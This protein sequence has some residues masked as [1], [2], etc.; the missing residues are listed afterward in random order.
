MCNHVEPHTVLEG[1]L[2]SKAAEYPLLFC[3]EFAALTCAHFTTQGPIPP[4]DIESFSQDAFR[5]Q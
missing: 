1:S 4:A 2:T 3:R 5:G